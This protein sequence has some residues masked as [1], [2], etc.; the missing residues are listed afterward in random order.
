MEVPY[1]PKVQAAKPEEP[2]KVA[3]RGNGRVNAAQ[4]SAEAVGADSLNLSAKGKTLAKLRS[5]YDK[6]SDTGSTVREIQQKIAEKG[7]VHLSSEEIVAGILHGTLF[8][9]I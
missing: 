8:Q 3:P 4:K 7:A 1:V 5:A 9:A 6:L 2:G